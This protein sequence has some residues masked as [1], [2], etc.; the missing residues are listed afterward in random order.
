MAL[1]Y[2]SSDK[3]RYLKVDEI[4]DIF[5]PEFI[6]LITFLHETFTP[7]VHELRIK[8]QKVLD[9]ALYHGIMP[10]HPPITEINSSTW[11]VQSVPSAL[12]TPGIEISGP[13]H[14][15]SM[16]IN[17]LNPNADRVSFFT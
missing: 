1:E 15:T 8:R 9:Q 14:V 17:A 11:N 2:L 10:A 12:Q 16:F 6:D 5:T 3:V 7:R 13:A 4:D